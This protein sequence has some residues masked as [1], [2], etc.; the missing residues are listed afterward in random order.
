[1]LTAVLDLESTEGA[2]TAKTV[3]ITRAVASV[4][5]ALRRSNHAEIGG[6]DHILAAREADLP[7]PFWQ[8]TYQPPL[9]DSGVTAGT[10]AD[11]SSG[12]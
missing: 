5:T 4:A 1:V 3:I 6:L 9:G 7:L 8:N 12:T 11:P 2:I 10:P